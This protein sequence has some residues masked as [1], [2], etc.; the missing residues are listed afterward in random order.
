[1]SSIRAFF[2]IDLPENVKQEIQ[3]M[4]E[5][6]QNHFRTNTVRWTRTHNLH[7][8]LQFLANVKET[9]L[10]N[11]IKHVQTE[12]DTMEEFD[13]ELGA[14]EL[15]PSSQDPRIISL[16]MGPHDRLA[17]LSHRIGQGILTTHYS[18]DERDFR[19]HLTLGR[20]QHFSQN[21]VPLENIALP[22][23][24]NFSVNKIVFYKSTPSEHASLYE[25]LAYLSLPPSELRLK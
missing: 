22:A 7:V 20:L 11:L 18:I 21:S 3:L 10:V 23:I 15:F 2:A 25:P 4:Q 8:T 16:Q 12:L 1:M 6:L 24:K 14:L 17:E 19:G 5:T 13:L 9:D